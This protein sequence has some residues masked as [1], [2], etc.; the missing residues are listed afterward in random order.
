[1]STFGIEEEFFLLHS[2]TGMP[3]A[4][5]TATSATLLAI[6]G[7]G[8]STQSELLACQSET[9][10]PICS[11]GPAAL[12]SLREYR[13][14]LARTAQGLNLLPVSL[15]T[16]P[17]VPAGPAIIA[18]QDRYRRIHEFLPGITGEQYVSGLHVHVSIP[19]P[20]AGVVALNALRPWL[21]LLMAVGSN[22]PFWHGADTGFAS[23]RNIHYRRWS[24]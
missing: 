10:T 21:P 16:I 20:D 2:V 4:P 7:G 14:E 12:A 1:M 24:V 15:G 17:L 22:S 23:W 8:N 19:D 5:D 13:Q 6:Q 11:D 18:D 9:A 3:A